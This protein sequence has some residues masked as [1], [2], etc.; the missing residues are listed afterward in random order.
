[1][2]MAWKDWVKLGHSD[3]L[4]G[5]VVASWNVI[6]IETVTVN[7]LQGVGVLVAADPDL[8]AWLGAGLDHPCCCHS[9]PCLAWLQLTE[10]MDAGRCAQWEW[11]MT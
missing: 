1:M 11:M 2:K 5:T 10:L 8:V 3:R 7:Q 6:E 9:L 4:R